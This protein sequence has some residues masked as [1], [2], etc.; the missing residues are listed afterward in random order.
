M[1]QKIQLGDKVKDRITGFTGIAT[2]KMEF[3]NG[4]IQYEVTP[5]M[6]KDN[7]MPEGTFIDIQSLEVITPKKTERIKEDTGG[8]NHKSIRMRGH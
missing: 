3:L 1:K 7:V 2:S 5:K 4:C 8:P 6:G